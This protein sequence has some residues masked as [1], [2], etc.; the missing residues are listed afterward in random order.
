MN[1]ILLDL[2]EL[3]LRTFN[4]LSQAFSHLSALTGLSTPSVQ[5]GSVQYLSIRPGDPLTPSLPAYNPSL[6]NSPSRL[7]RD[8]Q[9]LNIPSIP[10]LPISYEDAIPLLSSL[11]GLGQ[12]RQDVEGWKE[13][14]L[15]YKGVE[16]WTGPGEDK[17]ELRNGMEERL[18]KIWLVPLVSISLILGRK[19][20]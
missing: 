14:G 10:S 9:D 20:S 12:K 1:L 15:R 16:Y 6:P 3:L 7:P 17:I 19:G 18:T 8:S 4:S 5:R 13:G 11:N 2:L